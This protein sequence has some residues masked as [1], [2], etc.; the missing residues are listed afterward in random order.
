[1][2]GLVAALVFTSWQKPEIDP[3]AS[4]LPP[5]I[6]PRF[7]QPGSH[8]NENDPLLLIQA[9]NELMTLGEKRVIAYLR[10]W[11]EIDELG[12][13]SMQVF[14]PFWLVR[15]LFVGKGNN[16]VFPG[17][18]GTGFG[19]ENQPQKRW[20]AYPI[21]V[22][23]NSTILFF[24]YS[25]LIG[26]QIS[27]FRTYLDSDLPNWKFRQTKYVLPDDPFLILPKLMVPG[28][29]PE[30]AET[31][32]EA[33][34]SQIFKLVRTAYR[35][36]KPG[37]RRKAE[38]DLKTFE[39]LH[40]EFLTA[41]CHWDSRLSLYVRKDGSYD[42][43]PIEEFIAKEYKY[44]PLRNLKV[45]LHFDRQERDT[46]GYSADVSET[47]G[48]VTPTAVL[49]AVDVKTKKQLDWIHINSPSFVLP[50][51]TTIEKMLAEPRHSAVPELRR[52]PSTMKLFVDEKVQ[53][54]LHYDGK[55]YTSPELNP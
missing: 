30:G 16:Y 15:A 49:E 47:Y 52:T 10:A 34:V 1:M 40:Q 42:K 43:D 50:G 35:P 3:R 48:S 46:C 9:A 22:Y 53:F 19:N 2:I 44:P 27:P 13:W 54:V 8:L 31:T 29:S 5:N 20:P 25:S 14:F 39:I 26:G 36:A 55:T 18:P 38:N 37:Q 23:E 21:F 45:V 41:G 4:R 17:A 6:H 11:D 33:V 24:P 12:D 7:Y 32:Q 51:D 28:A